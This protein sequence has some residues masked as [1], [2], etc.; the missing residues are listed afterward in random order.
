MPQPGEE[1]KMHYQLQIIKQAGLQAGPHSRFTLEIPLGFP[2][3]KY[4]S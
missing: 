2:I 3:M 4:E 1:N